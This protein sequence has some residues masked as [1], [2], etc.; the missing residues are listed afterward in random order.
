MGSVYLANDTRLRRRVALKFISGELASDRRSRGRFLSEARAVSALN[1]PNVCVIY[2]VGETE[3]GWPYLA[4]ECVDGE[5]LDERVGRAGVSIDDTVSIA[6]QLV[7]ALD[8]AH[9]EGII[10]RDIKPAN[11]RLSKRGQLKVLDFG[12]AKRLTD[13]SDGSLPETMDVSQT[14]P[15]AVLGTP[16]Y[17]S[18]E[19]AT[20]REVDTRSDLFSTGVV[21]YQLV[22]GRVPFAGKT[23][24]EVLQKVVTAHP[25]ALARFN[26]DVP[27]SLERIIR[28]C[29]EKDPENR[30]QSAKEL[31]VDLRAIARDEQA[32][33]EVGRGE[34]QTIDLPDARKIPTPE[35]VGDSDVFISFANIDD[36]P[37]SVGRQG[38][39]SQFQ[40]NL[41]LRLGQLSGHD[42]RVWRQPD[43]AGRTG[44]ETEMIESVP[45]AKT[46]VSVVSPPFVKS[47]GCRKLVNK[48]WSH[49]QASGKLW[50]DD[51]SRLFK[52]VKTPVEPQ[53]LPPEL[54]PAFLD[55][56]PFDFYERDSETGRLREFDEAFGES[57]QQRFYERLYDLAYEICQVLRHFGNRDSQSDGGDGKTVFLAASTTDLEPHRDKVRR[58]LVELGHEVL[59]KQPLPLVAKELEAVVRGCLE[60]SD[61][62]V[63]LVS[64][65]Y[66]LVPEDTELS[67]VAM[68]NRIAAEVCGQGTLERLIW[69]SNDSDPQDDRQSEFIRALKRDPQHHRGA[70][71]II[72]SLQNF[73]LILESKCSAKPA[74]PTPRLADD[75]PRVY[76][77][78]D[79]M[80]EK[81]IE[82][83][84]DYLYE[85]GLEVCLPAFEVD[86]TEAQT[87]HVQNL[88]DCDAAL[89]YFGAAGKHWVDFKLRDL[90]KAAGYR[91]SKPIEVR[92][93]WMAPP[94]DRR[95]ERFKTL[96][97]D[98]IHQDGP[99]QPQLLADFVTSVK[100]AARS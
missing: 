61:L 30:Y 63:H 83:I 79:A 42:V 53:D 7:D 78:C 2:E 22:A 1:H 95:K 82:P 67:V 98:M 47:D 6:I 38:W 34:T 25:E 8:A 41:E 35:E 93:V 60:R 18:P 27:E 43:L 17:M 91:G 68:Q 50:V 55:L 69:I 5:S 24:A 72:D 100:G 49:A 80:D 4:M 65:S 10:H 81:A 96:S 75:P 20:G 19:Q 51:R 33:Q 85:A 71:V 97:A 23:L 40:R 11:L 66:G 94:F 92:A 56:V 31:L 88:T 28:K 64:D 37:I 12:L 84:E 58:T 57:A 73:K 87:I 3:R 14:S 16:S 21:L 48:F 36:R 44:L 32:R 15:G 54:A 9:T 99:F 76:L 52:V 77:I 89:I 45:N 39:I 86:E 26:Y 29:L 74:I 59:P 62:A 46:L 13:D 90:Q 70:D